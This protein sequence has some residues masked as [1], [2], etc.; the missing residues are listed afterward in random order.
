MP[1]GQA[2]LRNWGRKIAA[3]P[4]NLLHFPCPSGALRHTLLLHPPLASR[5][6]GKESGDSYR[7]RRRPDRE[8]GSRAGG[9]YDARRESRKPG[10]RGTAVATAPHTPRRPAPRR[11]I[12][13][14]APG[15][16][17]LVLAVPGPARRAGTEVAAELA[18][19]VEIEHT[20]QPARV[21]HLEGDEAACTASSPPAPQDDELAAV[22]VPLSTG[23]DRALDAAVHAAVANS[24]CAPSPPSRS[25]R[26]P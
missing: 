16:P 20:G 2:I 12:L 1:A 6:H 24:P 8:D 5:R 21:A 11:R 9:R 14:A 17:T 19:L 7:Q 23:P 4:D 3:N 26:T 15:S 22:V 25:A 10:T 13:P 18:R